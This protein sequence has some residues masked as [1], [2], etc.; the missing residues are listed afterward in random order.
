MGR[1][2]RSFHPDHDLGID[3]RPQADRADPAQQ[4]QSGGGGGGDVWRYRAGRHFGGD[5]AL[6]FAGRAAGAAAAADG[7]R[8]AQGVDIRILTEAGGEAVSGEMGEI[9]CRTRM[10]FGGYYKKPELTRAAMSGEYFR[11]GDLGRLDADG[12]LYF[13]GRQKDIIITGG[14]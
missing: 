6:S 5:A 13:L 12:Y 10:L 3:R 14:I 1:G 9:V 4:D 8:P 7:G 11:T 2:G